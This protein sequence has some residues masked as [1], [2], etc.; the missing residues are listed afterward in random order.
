MNYIEKRE[1]YERVYNVTV[2]KE[3]LQ[4]ILNLLVKLCSYKMTG[5]FDASY[6]SELDVENKVFTSGETLPDGSSRFEDI[7]KVYPPDHH[8]ENI[9][10]FGTQVVAPHLA[11]IIKGLINEDEKSLRDFLSYKD[12]DELVSIDEKIRRANDAVNHVDNSDYSRK[13]AAL[14][15]LRDLFDQKNN[16]EF[17]NTDLLRD[18]YEKATC[19]ISFQQISETSFKK[20]EMKLIRDYVPPMN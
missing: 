10:V 6:G 14:G 4:N 12:S 18:L 11:Y 15:N 19:A 9:R 7:K 8:S 13:V 3:E 5:I 2:N 16:K 20:G 17:F 1:D